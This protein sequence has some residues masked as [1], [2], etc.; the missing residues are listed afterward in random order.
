MKKYPNNLKKSVTM[1][2]EMKT[3][4]YLQVRIYINY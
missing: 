3:P 2:K 4:K 1:D